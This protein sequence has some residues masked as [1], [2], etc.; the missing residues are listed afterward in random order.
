MMQERIGKQADII[1]QQQLFLEK[2]NRKERDTNIVVLG[3]PDDQTALDGATNDDGKLNKE[4]R[5]QR[6][7]LDVTTLVVL[8]PARF[9]LPSPLRMLVTKCW[10]SHTS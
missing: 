5:S 4:I 2:I 8:A 7:D 9:W 6:K 1:M 10:R 3:V